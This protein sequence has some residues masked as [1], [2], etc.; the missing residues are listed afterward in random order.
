MNL[1]QKVQYLMDRKEI[2]D[3]CIAYAHAIDSRDYTLLRTLFTKDAELDFTPSGGM[4]GNIDEIVPF[5]E[6]NLG[7]FKSSQHMMTNIMVDF[8]DDGTAATRV[9][10]HNPMTLS[11][12]QNPEEDFTFYVGLWYNDTWVRTEKGWKI[13]KRVQ[14]ISYNGTPKA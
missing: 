6:Q 9:M 11:L 4:K 13:A 1:E 8:K 10:L 2:E 12:P 3:K 5:L 14:E 7:I